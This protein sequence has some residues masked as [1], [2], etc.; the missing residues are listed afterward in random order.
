MAH[1]S[2]INMFRDAQ[3][4]TLSGAKQQIDRGFA[5]R[6]RITSDAATKVI[7]KSE[8]SWQR[9]HSDVPDVHSQ[10]PPPY[11]LN[12]PDDSRGKG[13]RVLSTL[14]NRR[15]PPPKVS[16]YDLDYPPTQ[17]YNGSAAAP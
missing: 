8:V 13:K 14:A 17:S 15:Q 7:S 9:L 3:Y 12:K 11:I 6:A 16:R 2:V 5:M 4:E 10:A 1:P